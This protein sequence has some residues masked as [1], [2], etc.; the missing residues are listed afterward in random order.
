MEILKNNIIQLSSTSII[1]GF[2]DGI[3]LGHREVV[4]S[5]I[6]YAKKNNTK[7]LLITFK[8]SPAEYFNKNIKYIFER[9]D[10]YKLIEKLGVDYLLELDFSDYINISA[11][12]FLKFLK[13]NFSPKSISTGFNYTFG[14]N[15]NGNSNFLKAHQNIY[16][17]EYFCTPEYKI[18]NETIS[19]TNIRK[20]I[21][22]GNIKKA[23]EFLASNFK[24][25]SKVIKGNQLGRKLGYPTA[26]MN[27]PENIVKLPY[28]VY[29]VEVQNMPAILNWGIK[30]TVNSKKEVLEVHIPNFN[31]NLY[32]KKLEIKFLDKIRSEKKFNNL[33]ELKAQIEKD[34]ECL[35]L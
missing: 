23:N 14:K 28:G 24:L 11:E 25:K 12:D 10:N 8:S 17:Y 31:D 5:A 29:K 34:L 22:E 27:Y 1:L 35:K 16:N 7:T 6:N 21:L 9:E 33:E 3:H 15:R 4:L 20:L 32:N 26:N 19:S 30:P 13:E 2:F 18:N